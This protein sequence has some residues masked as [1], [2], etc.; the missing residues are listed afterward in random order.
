[1]QIAQIIVQETEL[2]GWTESTKLQMFVEI[3]H[4]PNPTILFGGNAD[5]SW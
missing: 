4:P 2:E 3:S 1:M 5:H